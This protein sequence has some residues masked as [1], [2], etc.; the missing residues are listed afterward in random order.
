MFSIRAIQ[1]HDAMHDTRNVIE[2]DIST[3]TSSDKNVG[4]EYRHDMRPSVQLPSVLGV[5][6]KLGLTTVRRS[7]QL[8]A[9][10]PPPVSKRMPDMRRFIGLIS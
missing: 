8:P 5:D 1:V 9:L 7:L 3:M 10:A 4:T 6:S 2:R